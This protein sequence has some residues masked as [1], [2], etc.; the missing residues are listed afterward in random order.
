MAGASVT[1]AACRT[2]STRLSHS[3]ARSTSR[4]DAV[5]PRAI[6]GP[7]TM[8][9]LT[10]RWGAREPRAGTARTVLVPLRGWSGIGGLF[11][12]TQQLERE[13]WVLGRDEERN[14]LRTLHS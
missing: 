4:V 10:S 8:V 5:S 12:E 9:S 6:E 1:L 11:A 3:A 2:A 7:P 13:P 14:V